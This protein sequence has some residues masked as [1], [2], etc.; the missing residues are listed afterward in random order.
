MQKTSKKVIPCIALVNLQFQVLGWN[1]HYQLNHRAAQPKLNPIIYL[2]R[3]LFL[4]LISVISTLQIN[5]PMHV[6]DSRMQ[7]AHFLPE[8]EFCD[9]ILD[10]RVSVATYVVGKHVIIIMI[11]YTIIVADQ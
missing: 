10:D 8:E 2:C 9:G 1:V 11:M 6:L 3:Q 5:L 7:F 4:K